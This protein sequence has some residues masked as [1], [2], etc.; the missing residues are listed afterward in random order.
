MLYF[1][2]NTLRQSDKNSSLILP[3]SESDMKKSFCTLLYPLIH[4][5]CLP[6]DNDKSGKFH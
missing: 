1:A 3:G 5:G 6:A 2:L 4:A